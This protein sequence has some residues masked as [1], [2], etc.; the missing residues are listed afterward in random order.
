MHHPQI[1]QYP[2][3][4]NSFFSEIIYLETDASI[5][6]FQFVENHFAE[7]ASIFSERGHKLA[8][9]KQKVNTLVG[10]GDIAR[11]MS[12]NYP[13]LYGAGL[14][15][16]SGTLS[17]TDTVA[18]IS[19][20]LLSY[21]NIPRSQFSGFMF[22][23]RGDIVL[24]DFP[25]IYKR[26]LS[27]LENLISDSFT[28]LHNNYE[29]EDSD[30]PGTY[31]PT[32]ESIK[33]Q[34]DSANIADELFPIE[35]HQLASEVMERVNKLTR[36]GFEQLL[37]ESLSQVLFSK[38]KGTD[39][40]GVGLSSIRITNNYRIIL[41]EYGE[42]EVELTP[43]PKVVFLFFL[44]HP[45]GVMFKRLYEHKEELIDLYKEVSL[46]EDMEAMHRSIEELVDPTKNSIN[47]KCSRIKEAFVKIMDDKF[48]RH[49]Y[50]TGDRGSE[51]RILLDRSMVVWEYE[52]SL[53]C[54]LAKSKED[55]A[56][57]QNQ[58]YE[59]IDEVENLRL[60]GSRRKGL[61]L[62]TGVI[63]ANPYNTT[64]LH[65]RAILHF[66]LQ[67]RNL[68]IKDYTKVIELNDMHSSA[69]YN[70]ALAYY[71]NYEYGK[72]IADLASCIALLQKWDS[73]LQKAHK[74]R[75]DIYSCQKNESAAIADY[76]IAASLG[77][78]ESKQILQNS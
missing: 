1:A 30:L 31:R 15:I 62:L 36:Y 28:F 69:F 57:I 5:G 52:P 22:L 9:I 12:Y 10:Y 76:R 64:A 37:I 48:A 47:E 8:S 25:S 65:L 19:R 68:A 20:M 11:L 67:Q 60:S 43:L 26:S 75:A 29:E 77:C 23:F 45:E 42:H 7:I 4:Q 70:R 24:I 13:L 21:F 38:V 50:I 56:I 14:Q 55:I 34:G 39:V 32:A 16:E 63:N 17:G 74:F 61:E 49:Y 6:G 72:A 44:R 78:E 46:R 59:I 27:E 18:M 73:L 66:E 2:N 3:P 51:K 33:K 35:A 71:T 54:V 41:T 53:P 40:A 58:E